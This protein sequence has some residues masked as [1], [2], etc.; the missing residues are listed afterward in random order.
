MEDG[1]VWTGEAAE[2]DGASRGRRGC[3]GE[4]GGVGGGVDAEGRGFGSGGGEGERN[5]GEVERRKE[6]LGGG[7]GGGDSVH[8]RSH[9]RMHEFKPSTGIGIYFIFLVDD[10]RR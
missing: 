7:S 10:V 4:G 6:K 5:G 2:G 8:H 9:P 3:L 1:E